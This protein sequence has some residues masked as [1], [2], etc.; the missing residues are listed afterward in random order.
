GDLAG[1]GDALD[2]LDPRAVA[3]HRK[4]QAAAH[5][6][7]VD[8]QRAG[9]AHAMLAADM[10]AGEAE[11]L[12]QEIDNA[13][14][15]IDTLAHRL[16]V[17]GALDLMEAPPPARGSMSCFAPRRVST[18]AR[19]RFTALVAWTSSGGSRPRASAATAASTSPPASAASAPWAR[20]G[21][22]PTLKNASRTSVSVLPF[23]R[24]VAA[25]PAIA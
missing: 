22:T 1:V 24:A 19:R 16:A 4:H 18:P 7:A 20:T 14:P 21:V 5:D 11:G 10:A 17:D 6:H 9:A 8:A 23:A 15:R 2:G 25:S 13:L 12:A 3:L